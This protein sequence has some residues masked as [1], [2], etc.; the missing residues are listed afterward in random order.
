MEGGS[1]TMTHTIWYNMNFDAGD[2][3]ISEIPKQLLPL[4]MVGN[5]NI[6]TCD[7]ATY[8]YCIVI[9]DYNWVIFKVK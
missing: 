3:F 2:I 5:G 4:S 9:Y 6:T 8:E 7:T 1:S